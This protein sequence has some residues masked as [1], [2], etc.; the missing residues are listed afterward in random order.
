[1]KEQ[2]I[3][4]LLTYFVNENNKYGKITFPNNID[5]KRKMLRGITNGRYYNFKGRCNS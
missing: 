3:D 1:M 4:E 2:L 5:E